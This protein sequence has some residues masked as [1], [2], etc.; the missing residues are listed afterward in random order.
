MRKAI[1]RFF[2]RRYARMIFE[3][4]FNLNPDS[5]NDR[6]KKYSEGNQDIDEYMERFGKPDIEGAKQH[7]KEINLNVSASLSEY[8]TANAKLK[9]LL[10]DSLGASPK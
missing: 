3:S 8:I 10:F 2:S 9:Q 4:Q 7:F 5:L 6:I 1:A